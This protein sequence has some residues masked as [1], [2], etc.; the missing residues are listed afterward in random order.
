MKKKLINIY[1]YILKNIYNFLS[2]LFRFFE[3]VNTFRHTKSWFLWANKTLKSSVFTIINTHKSYKQLHNA[4]E[5]HMI[6][7][8]RNDADHELG[9]G[10]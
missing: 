4:R 7:I 2:V 3:Q 1:T 9:I 6:A 5:Q 8:T 10:H